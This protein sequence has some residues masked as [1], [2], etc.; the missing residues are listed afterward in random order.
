MPAQAETYACV[1]GAAIRAGVHYA[2][3]VAALMG[4]SL[5]SDMYGKTVWYTL[6]ALSGGRIKLLANCGVVADTIGQMLARVDNLYTNG[7]P[8]F[9]GLAALAGVNK[10]GYAV[11]R[12]GTNNI[13]DGSTIDGSTAAY[14][15]LLNA[16]AGYATKVIILGVTPVWGNATANASSIAYNVWLSNF[17]AANP[18][19]FT[20]VDDSL[21]LRLPNGDPDPAYQGDD[22][23]YLSA[24]IGPMGAIA[25]AALRPMLS[26]YAS[27]LS[28]DPADVYPA[29][30]QWVINPTMSGAGGTKGSGF[31]GTV[32]SNFGVIGNSATAVMSIVP[33]DGGDPNQTPWQRIDVTGANALQLTPGTQGRS[34]T[35][36]DPMQLDS[37]FELRLIN[38]D[39]TKMNAVSL[40]IQADTTEFIAPSATLYFAPSAS[41]NA[42]YVLRNSKSRAGATSPSYLNYGIDF[43][44]ATPGGSAGAFDVRCVSARG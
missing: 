21:G 23:H 26:V 25:D 27:P 28:T 15:S 18:D 24:G 31:S 10:I 11:V 43:A 38:A 20:F 7:A 13:R 35:S 14:T 40:T 41:L 1:S 36:T 3:P 32:A 2:Q 8:G 17:A 30:P 29:Q 37:M 12:A 16:L 33:A 5:T 6:N 4:D 42:T 19:V 22:V 34:M 9:A 39:T 44:C